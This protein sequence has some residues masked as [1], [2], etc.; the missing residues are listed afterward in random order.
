M[1]HNA[2]RDP[3][4]QTTTTTIRLQTHEL[5]LL[6]EYAEE[7]E[8]SKN[9]LIVKEVRKLLKRAGKLPK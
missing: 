3:A 6:A 5:A 9:S 2:K 1:R 4:I 7:K 8:V